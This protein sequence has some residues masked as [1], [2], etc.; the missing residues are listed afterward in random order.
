MNKF[1]LTIILGILTTAIQAQNFNI[2]GRL[3]D[4]SGSGLPSATILLLNAKDSVM[5]NYALSSNDGGFEVRNIRRGEYLLR[6]SYMGF[7]T[8]TFPVHPPN[9]NILDLGDLKLP[10]EAKILREVTVEQ[11]RIPMR[12]KNDTIEYDALAFRPLP[13]EMVEDLLKRMPGMVVASDGTVEAQGE[14]VRR[15]L[16]DGKE[17]FGRDPKMATQNIAADAVARVQVFDQRSEQTIFT[18]IDDGQRERTLNLEL[19]E[20]RKEAAFGNT[21]LGYGPDKR[22]QGRANLNR[23][24]ATGQT[25]L[26][27]MGNNVN[28]QGF[29]V[30][31]YMNFSGGTQSLARGTGTFQFGGRQNQTGVPLNFDGRASSNGLITSWAGGV[32]FNRTIRTGTEVTA[33]YFYN[34]LAH[35][36]NEELDRENYLPSGNYNY[37]QN[38]VQ[39]NQNYNHRL[40][41]RM[42]HKFSESSSL[43]FTGSSTLNMSNSFGQ[44]SGQTFGINGELQNTGAQTI[45]ADGN[46]LDIN[47]SL[48]YRQRLA[49]P[50]RT[51]TAGAD[52]TQG[53]NR[54]DALLNAINRFYQQIVTEELILQDQNR[55]DW[56]RRLSGNITYT[57]PIAN[58]V[59]LE[60]NYN[61]SY[62]LDEV[63]LRVFDLDDINTQGQLNDL[64]SNHYENT[65]T[66]QRA[67]INL[68]INRDKYNLTVGSAVQ[69]SDLNGYSFSLDQD[70]TR[71]YIH[72][73][74]VTRFNYEFNGFR[75]LSADYETSVQE[76][77]ALQIQPVVD[78]RDPLN[79]YAGNP[80]LLPSYR[81][82]W[83][84]RFNSFNPATSF[85]FFTNFSADY[86]NNAITN[87][88][89]V[90]ENLVRTTTPVNV[91]NNVNLRG[92]VNLNIGVTRLKSNFMFGSSVSRMQSVN[93]LNGASQQIVNNTVSPNFRY[94][95]RPV[96]PFEL[97]L[98]ASLNHQLTR[99][100]FSTTEQAY[101]NQTYQANASWSFLNN[102]RVEGNYNYNLYQGRTSEFD[103]K[104]PMLNMSFSRSF[105]RNNSGELKLSVFNLL[106]SELG[107]TQ[108]TAVNYYERS[109][110]NSLGRYFLLTFTYSLNRQLNIMDRG[111]GSGRGGGRGMRMIV[112]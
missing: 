68:R 64:L 10:E 78:N 71:N 83:Q 103:R 19:K 37:Q 112:N 42:D 105:M 63:N 51:L 95:F 16:V 90:D 46:K 84:V 77:S 50:G 11:E 55:K 111:P 62:A 93:V 109:V 13:N 106:D 74:P 73:L 47:A 49:K 35:D 67:G 52:I 100:E 40:N 57:E 7:A 54:Q 86:I 56:N 33:S 28:Q 2:K 91:D 101:L 75:R 96:D 30:G 80:D 99:Y 82:R 48:L 18:G 6:L 70:V 69:S 24:K 41:L 20:D 45:D 104:I 5:V 97:M 53:N 3:T 36:M 22:F 38:R 76:P 81:H 1:F 8:V 58:R 31:D 92:N 9:E 26:L 88:V 94:I 17:F 15:V 72:Y 43:L 27:A 32:N 98:T 12:V 14:Q 29:S 23:F 44:T 107:V 59:F 39:D 66:F 60:G 25:S 89:S 102:Y 61:L 108:T 34:Q 110:T 85:G 65:Y 4:E 21:S 79:I 87:S